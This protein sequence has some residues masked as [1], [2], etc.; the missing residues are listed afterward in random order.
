MSP[1][2]S[3]DHPVCIKIWD[4]NH[5]EVLEQPVECLF[6]H[7][8]SESCNFDPRAFRIRVA[9][10]SGNCQLSEN[11]DVIDSFVSAVFFPF[12]A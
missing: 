2:F 8:C 11:S 6:V 4:N 7:L 1:C 9:A 12:E 10:T 3:V 5:V